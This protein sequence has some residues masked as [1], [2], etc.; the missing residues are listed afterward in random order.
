MENVKIG[1]QEFFSLPT[2]EKKKFWQK[3]GELEGLG[4]NFVV[5]EE[6]KLEWADMFYIFTLPLYARNTHLF[7]SIPQPFRL[8]PFLYLYLYLLQHLTQTYFVSLQRR[9]RE[10][11]FRIGETL[12]HND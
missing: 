4:Q 6:Q 5:S 2:E 8:S 9:S 7:S 10:L 3:P 12:C 11:L 1:V